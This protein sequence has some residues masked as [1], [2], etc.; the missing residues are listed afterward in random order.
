MA[1]ERERVVADVE[2]LE[3][4]DARVRGGGDARGEVGDELLAAVRFA[5]FGVAG[6]E[7]ELVLRDG[8]DVALGHGGMRGYAPAYFGGLAV[9]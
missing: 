7:E 1:V 3:A 5:G 6:E 9:R 4:L 8:L 2:E